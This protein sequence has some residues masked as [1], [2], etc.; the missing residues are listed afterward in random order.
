MR[1]IDVIAQRTRRANGHL[2]VFALPLS[3]VPDAIPV[4]R[5]DARSD[6]NRL[7]NLRHARAFA[8]YWS[9]NRHWAAPPLLLDTPRDL[10][11]WFAS[12]FRSDGLEAG[13]LTLPEPATS[14]LQILDGQHRVYGWY[15]V[16]S[17]LQER[18]LELGERLA[19]VRSR[20]EPDGQVVAEIERVVSLADRLMRDHVTVEVLDRTGLEEH[21]Q[22]FFDIASNAK[23]ITKSLTAAFDQRGAI[24]K[25]VLRFVDEYEPLN[26]LVE[27]EADR[28]GVNSSALLTVAQLLS[29][30]E[31]AV[32]G[33]DGWVKRDH[34]DALTVES[35]MDVATAALDTLFDGF[36]DLRDV[37]EKTLGVAELRRTS[38]LGSV[39]FLRVLVGV[40]HSLVVTLGDDGYV[41]DGEALDDVVDFFQSISASMAESVPD[42]L[43]ASGSFDS[44]H[45]RSPRARRQESRAVANAVVDEFRSCAETRSRDDAHAGPQT[46]PTGRTE[47]DAQPTPEAGPRLTELLDIAQRRGLLHAEE[48]R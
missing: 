47:T 34:A 38:L 21:K 35:V 24:N 41:V 10:G 31:A 20:G 3:Q 14:G 43:W 28:V 19:R 16:R 37:S 36:D 29:L 26:G 11:P 15:D 2:Y 9:T 6:G 45:S 18:V 12:Q 5:T 27:R 30:V 4:P 17:G 33:I 46:T 39:T 42:W 8:T 44:R 13:V 7:L 1:T 22:W 40:F 23:G 48:I 25:A 32:L